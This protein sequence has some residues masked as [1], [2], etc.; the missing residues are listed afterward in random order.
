MVNLRKAQGILL[1]CHADNLIDDEEFI[2]LYDVTKPANP[3]FPYW[4][5]PPFDFE[6]FSKSSICSLVDAL[7]IPDEVRCPNR[8]SIDVIDAICVLLK[9]NSYP[10]RFS[11]LIP[12]FGRSVAELCNIASVIN[13]HIF[14]THGPL[15]TNLNQP[16]LSTHQLQEFADALHH[17]G[18]P[19]SN[20]WGFID[21][22]V[23]P[24]CR[25]SQK[26][27]NLYNG[28]K[29]IHA[30]KFQSIAAPNGLI[31]NLYGPIE[32]KRHDNAMLA[33]YRLLDQMLLHCNDANGHPSC[34]YGDAAYPL[35]AHLQK[36]FQGAR[37]NG[38]QK[39][40]DTAMSSVRTSAEWLFGDVINYC[41]FMDFLKKI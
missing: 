18:A 24:I 10:C 29:R 11:D 41:K 6:E 26:Q 5:Y 12:T 20:C 13:N 35:R 30:I 22:T 7:R 32:G 33:E 37:L 39:E 36:P 2:L 40:F 25:P 15:L 8:Q 3:E 27:R 4:T 14:E 21:G 16:W 34:V 38:Q 1:H 17:K 9:R 23:R 31:A 19:L 28:Y